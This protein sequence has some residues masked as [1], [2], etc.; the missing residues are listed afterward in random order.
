MGFFKLR[1]NSILL[2][3]LGIF[4]LTGFQN[5]FALAPDTLWQ[6]NWEGNWATDWH[7]DAGTWEIGIPTSGP[8]SVYEGQ[9]CAAT[10]LNGKYAEGIRTRLIRHTYFKNKDNDLLIK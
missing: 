5:S 9:T 4:I 7:V 2:F 10:V 1:N 6:E 3:F 8:D